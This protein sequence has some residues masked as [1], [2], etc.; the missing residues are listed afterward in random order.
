MA[1]AQVELARRPRAAGR[2]AHVDDVGRDQRAR[3]VGTVA[4]GVH[5]HRAADRAG[6]ARPPIRNRRARRQR[7]AA[8]PPAGVWHRRLGARCRRAPRSRTRRRARWRR[9]ETRGRTPSR[10]DPLPI[11]STSTPTAP[12]RATS[13]RSLTVAHDTN[14]SA[15]PPTRYVVNGPNGRSNSTRNDGAE[16]ASSSRAQPSASTLFTKPPRPRTRRPPSVSRPRAAAV[17]RAAT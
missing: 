1:V 3:D 11:T 13:S 9:L 16:R 7:C 8:R 10:L 6:H 5:A 2:T 14:R 17:R 4:S 15:D 12:T